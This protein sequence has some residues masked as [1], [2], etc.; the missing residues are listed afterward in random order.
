MRT[1]ELLTLTIRI[2]ESKKKGIDLRFCMSI[3]E[4]SI[5]KQIEYSN[6]KKKYYGYVDFGGVDIDREGS[7]VATKALVLTLSDINGHFKIPVAYFLTNGLTSEEQA[8][9]VN[10][11]LRTLSENS[12]VV[13]AL[14]FDGAATNISMNHVL[15]R[16][17]E[18]ATFFHHP[19]TKERIYIVWDICHTIKLIRNTLEDKETLHDDAQERPIEWSSMNSKI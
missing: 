19:L 3:D 14:D 5:R 6:S 11:V 17:G 18:T 2:E 4:M 12:V 9:V 16:N 13:V 10:M 8:S 7:T 15:N 1:P